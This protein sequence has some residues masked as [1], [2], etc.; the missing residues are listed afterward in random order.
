MSRCTQMY[1]NLMTGRVKG[2]LPV[3]REPLGSWGEPHTLG[4]GVLCIVI[5]LRLDFIK[6]WSFMSAL[7]VASATFYSKTQLSLLV[8][9]FANKNLNF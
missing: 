6:D 4:G 8:T 2:L 9:S 5:P 1:S 7:Q 3:Y